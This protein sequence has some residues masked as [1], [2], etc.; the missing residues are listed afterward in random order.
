LSSATIS[1][2]LEILVTLVHLNGKILIKK[3]LL[4]ILFKAEVKITESIHSSNSSANSSQS[5]IGEVLA[6]F[7]VKVKRLELLEF[8]KALSKIVHIKVPSL[9][10]KRNG[11][12]IRRISKR[13]KSIDH[14]TKTVGTIGSVGIVTNNEESGF[15]YW[16]KKF[17][18]IML[19]SNFSS[20]FI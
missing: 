14:R 16:E 8:S 15:F 12:E 7:K 5:F 11:L 9:E 2:T 19:K 10:I 1:L 3:I 18:A 4:K 6:P 20:F 13:V 17:Y